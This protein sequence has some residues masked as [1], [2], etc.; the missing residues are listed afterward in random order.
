MASAVYSQV[1]FGGAEW[2]GGFLGLYPAGL[3]SALFLS[4]AGGVGL[5]TGDP[6]L[7]DVVQ[8]QTINRSTAGTTPTWVVGRGGSALNFPTGGQHING[9]MQAL[10]PQTWVMWMIPGSNGCPVAKNDA[11]SINAGWAVATTSTQLQFLV[12]HATTNMITKVSPANWAGLWHHVAIVW[13]GSLTSANTKI[14]VDGVLQT[15]V[16]DQNGVGVHGSDGTFAY[17]IGETTGSFTGFNSGIWNN[18]TLESVFLF[19]RQLDAQEINGLYQASY[20]WYRPSRAYGLGAAGADQLPWRTL[21]RK[22]EDIFEEPR[23][24]RSF[25]ALFISQQVVDRLPW[26][27]ARRQAEDAVEEPYKQARPIPTLFLPVIFTKL[28][29]AQMLQRSATLGIQ[30]LKTLTATMATKAGSLATSLSTNSKVLAAMA[31]T[32]AGALN[33]RVSITLAATMAQRSGK[34]S[35]LVIHGGPPPVCTPVATCGTPPA[36]SHIEIC[37]NTGS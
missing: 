20:R 3:I 14:Y 23:L 19:N 37:E 22:I 32:K 17:L 27:A 2:P 33:I 15:H 8:R 9:Y 6:V 4:E 24:A 28:L 34:L 16:S 12:E 25:V 21:N 36:T 1:K 11:N 13:D 31:S 10:D 5:N 7:M 29:T 18:G 35:I 26:R 30:V